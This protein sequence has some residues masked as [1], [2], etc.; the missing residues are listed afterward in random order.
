MTF[1]LGVV[2]LGDVDGNEPPS[3]TCDE[4]RGHCQSKILNTLGARRTVRIDPENLG[5]STATKYDSD[6]RAK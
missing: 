6:V 5:K 2:G 4:L 1:P 3:M